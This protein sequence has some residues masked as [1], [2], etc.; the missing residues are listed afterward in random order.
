MQPIDIGIANP[1]YRQTVCR[2]NENETVPTLERNPVSLLALVPTPGQ[3]VGA[4]MNYH[5]Y[6]DHHRTQTNLLLSVSSTLRI[7]LFN[8]RYSVRRV[9]GEW[10][11]YP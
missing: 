9:S 1:S 6:A 11:L 4:G 7:I 5:D 8:P 10:L 3:I 2:T